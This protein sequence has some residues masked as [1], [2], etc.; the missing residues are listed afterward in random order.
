MVTSAGSVV[1]FA[2]FRPRVGTRSLSRPIPEGRL[3]QAGA[4]LAGALDL[5]DDGV[6]PRSGVRTA[7]AATAYAPVWGTAEP[8]GDLR[9]TA[10]TYLSIPAGPSPVLALRAGAH[11]VW[12][13]FPPHAAAVI[14]GWSTL[15]GYETERFAGDAALWGGAE[16]RAVL[17]RPNLF[18]RGDL[19]ALAFADAGR[20]YLNRAS[21]GG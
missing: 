14:G 9:T 4:R 19:G 5:R 1:S 7:F 3:G 12:G 16:L 15:R 6:E 8:F 10:S 20:V 18:L 11:Q 2:N 17:G 21:P 13:D